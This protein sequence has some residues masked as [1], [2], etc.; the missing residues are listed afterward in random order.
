MRDSYPTTSCPSSS[1]SLFS[2]GL[3]YCRD[4][5]AVQLMSDLNNLTAEQDLDAYEEEECE[6]E[7]AAFCQKHRSHRVLPLKKKK[8]RCSLDRPVWDPLRTAYEE[9][10]DGRDT[11]ILKSWR[12]D[13]NEPRQYALLRGMLT[14]ATTVQL[15]EEPLRGE[16]VHAFSCSLQTAD[17]IV[18]RLQRVAAALPVSELPPVYCSADDPCLLFASP[19]KQHVQVFTK[20]CRETSVSLDTIQVQDFFI[21]QQQEDSLMLELRQSCE[22]HFS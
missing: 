8:D 12:P 19:D 16:L 10:T 14:I 22:I 11:F 1:V 21:R 4:C 2:P 7:E 5:F 6:D 9:V 20:L 15:P 17:A 18:S 3:W 13:L